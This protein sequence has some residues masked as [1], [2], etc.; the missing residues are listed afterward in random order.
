MAGDD[1]SV[2]A[3]DAEAHLIVFVTTVGY[4]D[5][6]TPAAADAKCA[7]EA[8]GR[9]PGHFV[10]WMSGPASPAPA[11]LLDNHGKTVGGPWFR[12]DGKRV[13]GSRSALSNAA[14]KALENPIEITAAGTT[15][16]ASV[17]TGTLGDGGIGKLCPTATVN[18]TAGTASQ[19]G[20][21]WTQQ[22]EFNASCGSSL[23][24]YCFQVD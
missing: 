2:E 7:G 13:V 20:T 12:P 19:T 4:A 22:T 6:S 3:G 24:L 15:N 17:W 14:A 11:R 10:A 18:P 9:L 8:L 5:V 16:R 1:V 23:A 21:Q